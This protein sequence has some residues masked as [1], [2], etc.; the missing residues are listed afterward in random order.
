M[1]DAPGQNDLVL[2]QAA[3]GELRVALGTESGSFQ[4]ETTINLPADVRF[5]RGDGVADILGA[6]I[7]GESLDFPFYRGTGTSFAAGADWGTVPRYKAL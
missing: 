1:N 3:V 5:L 4:P 2:F 7:N 6:K